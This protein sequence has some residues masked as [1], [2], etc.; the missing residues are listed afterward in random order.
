MNALLSVIVTWLLISFGLPPNYAHP[1]IVFAPAEQIADLRYGRTVMASRPKVFAVYDDSRNAVLLPQRWTPV[2]PADLSVL[3]HEMV[4]H[5]QNRA[6]LRY[7]CAE[8]REALAY[9]AQEKW[10]EQYGTNLKR[11]FAFDDLV[12]MLQTTCQI[13]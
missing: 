8:E 12:L 1:R 10:L 6:G 11:E 7:A 4:H 5:L 2:T 3:V 9:A 13:P